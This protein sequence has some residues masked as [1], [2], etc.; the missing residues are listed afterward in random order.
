[1][2]NNFRKDTR[3]NMSI[4]FCMAMLPLMLAAGIAVD[5]SAGSSARS[6]L[7]AAVDAAALAGVALQTYEA[8]S[9]T[10]EAARIFNTHL[11]LIDLGSEIP[12]PN[13]AVEPEKVTVSASADVRTTFLQ[14]V[15]V[16][17]VEVSTSATAVPLERTPICLLALNPS[18]PSTISVTGTAE[19]DASE[20]AVH[21]NS[22]DPA[23]LRVQ[24]AATA[25]AKVFCSKGGY[26]GRNFE[27]LPR[28]ECPTVPDPYA[29][30]PVPSGLACDFNDRTF[31][32]G[33]HTAVPGVYCGG[34]DVGD[35][36]TVT[37]QPGVY[38]VRDGPLTMHA[39][40]TVVGSGVTFY[41][42][43][44]DAVLN[45]RSFSTVELTA[46]TSGPY[47]GVAFAQHAPS[48][49]GLTSTL[50]GG[51][52]IRIVGALHFPTQAIDIGGASGVDA[53]LPYMPIV[54]DR[55]IL[56]GN[57]T[58]PVKAD[59]KAAGFEDVLAKLYTGARL[60]R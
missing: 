30:L 56:R 44:A 49:A 60:T 25:S 18:A 3:G 13:V 48:S 50:A 9:K 33:A 46:P 4:L 14:V 19:L 24:G 54:A 37:L 29:G 55:F 8:G 45:I 59:Y 12:T 7:Q 51:A 42:Y 1:M 15:G 26:H 39:H 53:S 35:H 38:V 36:A 52:W 28:T 57:G 22:S 58:M 6:Q 40:S 34:M 20:C 27:P 43:G 47:A 32:S 31:H 10:E 2:R 21:A 11:Q 41:F 16:N 23:A 5:Y 17:T